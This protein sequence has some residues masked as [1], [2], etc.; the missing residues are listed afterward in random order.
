MLWLNPI[1]RV[2]VTAQQAKALCINPEWVYSSLSYQGIVPSIDSLYGKNKG[3]N[4]LT[5]LQALGL[6][7]IGNGYIHSDDQW[8]VTTTYLILPYTSHSQFSYFIWASQGATKD[9]ISLETLLTYIPKQDTHLKEKHSLGQESSTPA[10]MTNS[11]SIDIEHWLPEGR[12]EI[13]RTASYNNISK[14]VL[15]E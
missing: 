8:W 11:W 7:H 15:V 13:K 1:S 12:S 14:R 6:S 10:V 9:D 5:M 4:P 2:L 3:W